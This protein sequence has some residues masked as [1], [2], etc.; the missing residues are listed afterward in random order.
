MINNTQ[1]TMHF[2]IQNE[3]TDYR[4]FISCWHGKV[5][6]LIIIDDSTEVVCTNF[7]STV[8]I[9]NGGNPELWIGKVSTNRSC[10]NRIW[11]N[12]KQYVPANLDLHHKDDDLYR[13][14]VKDIGILC[15]RGHTTGYTETIM[16]SP[17]ASC[18][19]YK[20]G[21]VVKM[22]YKDSIFAKEGDSG[23]VVIEKE[24]GYVIGMITSS[25]RFHENSPEEVFVLPLMDEQFLAKYELL[26]NDTVT[27][28][29]R[30]HPPEPLE[31]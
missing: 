24:T 26:K 4:Y 7:K 22:K 8:D 12:D 9:K 31:W 20:R 28:G 1:K 29:T 3:S 5:D 17:D 18:V 13:S 6:R 15:K 11:D 16:I 2:E 25:F 21:V 14:H 27:D 19:E 23:S 10:T 30:I